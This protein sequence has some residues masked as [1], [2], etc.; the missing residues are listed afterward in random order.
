MVTQQEIV[1][2]IN[3]LAVGYN[4]N[5]GDIK[6]DAD[7]AIKKI[8]DFLGTKYPKMSEVL[9]SPERYYAFRSGVAADGPVDTPYFPDEHIFSIVTPFIAMEVLARD[10]EFTTIYN[11]Y[12]LE[13]KDGL[14]SMFQTEFNR[15]PLAFRQDPDAGVFFASDSALGE[16]ARN[17]E[18]DLPVY[19][20]RVHYHVND[21]RINLGDA[22]FVED[23][24]AYSYEGSAIVKGWDDELISVDGTLVFTFAGWSRDPNT[25]SSDIAVGD[26]ITMIT[27]IHLYANWTLQSTLDNTPAG[28]LTI[29]DEYKYSLTQLIIPNVVNNSIVR[30]I[31]TDFLKSTDEAYEDATRLMSITLPDLLTGIDA[32]AFDGF[33]GDT[34][35][36]PNTVVDNVTYMGITIKANAFANT[37]NLASIRLPANVRTVYAGAFPAVTLNGSIDYREIACAILEQNKPDWDAVELTGWH[38]DWAAGDNLSMNYEVVVTWGY[39]G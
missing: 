19:K 23:L 16:I 11:K 5:W 25:V 12:D 6:R 21:A 14:F 20:F 17:G 33:Q 32:N 15:V 28:L 30:T 27:D 10:E 9:D 29:K 34:I 7:K 36:F 26:T 31:D 38:D 2:E 8:N 39:N 4:L 13:V 22:S 1:D 18:A 37:P 35:N 3:R 24:T